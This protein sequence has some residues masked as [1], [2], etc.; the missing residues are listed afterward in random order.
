MIGTGPITDR[1]NAERLPAQTIERD[2]L[3]AHV[4]AEIGALNDSRIVFKG[5]TLLRLCFF[6]TY[7]YSADL[8]FSTVDGLSYAEALAL[9]NKAIT[10]CRERLELPSLDISAGDGTTAWI[11]YIGPLRSKERRLKLDIS[12]TELVET[13]RQMAL[14]QNWPDLPDGSAIEGYTLDEV[15]GE[16]LRCIA[17]RVQCRDLYDLHELLE[18]GHIEPLEAWELYLRKAANDLVKGKQRTPPKKWA[19]SFEQR[20]DAYKDR[21]V[22]EL[23]DYVP[24]EI[25]SFQDVERRS[26]KRLR[27]VIAEARKLAG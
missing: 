26:R 2:Y 1:A 24:L 25:P 15:G 17:E 5:G 3:L 8:D 23:S 14:R 12:D 27:R 19:A 11:T 22:E 10:A 6:E 18:G 7:R 4:C 20:L 13:H 21:W 9:V 16:K